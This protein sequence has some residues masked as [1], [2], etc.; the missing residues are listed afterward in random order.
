LLILII[1]WAT[2]I[3]SKCSSFELGSG[4]DVGN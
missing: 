4:S 2:P 1:D 3:V